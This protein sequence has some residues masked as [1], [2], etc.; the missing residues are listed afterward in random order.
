MAAQAGFDHVLYA[1]SGSPATKSRSDVLD[2]EVRYELSVAATAGDRELSASRVNLWQPG[3]SWALTAVD[4]LEQQFPNAEVSFGISGEYLDPNHRWWLKNW[5]GGAELFKRSVA[6]IFPRGDQ[7]V[8][9][10][11]DWAKLVPEARIDVHYAP[12][13][14]VSATQIR[15]LVRQGRSIRYLTA[16]SVVDRIN[17]STWFRGVES[18]APQV[19]DASKPV[20]SVCLFLSEF[21]PI[22]LGD[23]RR[24]EI[25]R[26]RYKFDR[27]EFVPVAGPSQ[28]M[29]TFAPAEIRYEMALA[30]TNSNPFFAASRLDIDF[31]ENS[32]PLFTSVL[33]NR[34]YAKSERPDWMVYAD[35]LNPEHPSWI[36]AWVGAPLVWFDRIVYVLPTKTAGALQ[37]KEWAKRLPGV[38]IKIVDEQT[39]TVSAGDV[40]QWVSSRLPLAYSVPQAVEN[41][42]YKNGLYRPNSFRGRVPLPANKPRRT[43]R[44]KTSA[45]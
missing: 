8:E 9:Q 30:A 20:K 5:I 22:T 28:T 38:R 17:N 34:K 39:D 19:F 41:I 40:R 4:G 13:L 25:A 29:K 10:L 36:G 24:A 11:R 27:V 18:L 12:D 15:D 42:I 31:D 7:S 3:M 16:E 21:D 45:A 1:V 33:V 35:W 2:P 26:E 23:L 44:V 37:A 14:P 6:T 32:F 43:S